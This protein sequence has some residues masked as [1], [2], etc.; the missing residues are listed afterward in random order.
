MAGLADISLANFT[1]MTISGSEDMGRATNIENIQSIGELTDESN[2]IDVPEYNVKYMRKLVGSA[3]AG[4]IDVTC[5]L[6]AGDGSYKKMEAAYTT[7]AP[8]KVELIMTDLSGEN[9]V[10]VSFNAFIASK[11]F[12][13]EFDNTR[14]VTWS[15]AVD[16]E[17]SNITDLE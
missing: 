4:P 7:G 14:T 17:V 12:G 9:G 1:K 15:F 8:L 11:S 5:N 6:H 13:N 2:I 10:K 3:S 16:G